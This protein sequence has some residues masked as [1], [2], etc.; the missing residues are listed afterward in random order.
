MI[1]SQA[2]TPTGAGRLRYPAVFVVRVDRC[3]GYAD[4]AFQDLDMFGR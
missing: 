3:A 1:Q 4:M 2:I